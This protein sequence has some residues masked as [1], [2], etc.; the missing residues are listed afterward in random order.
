MT[1]RPT[2]LNDLTAKKIIDT[3]AAGGSR[4]AA[5]AAAGVHPSTV[6]RWL[7]E[8]RD[9]ASPYREF[10]ER[11]KG[12]E[13][14]AEIAMVTVVREAALKGTWQAAAWW[15]ERRR[16][17]LYALRRDAPKPLAEMTPEQA[18]ARY[19]ELTGHDWNGGRGDDLAVAESVVSA[20]RSRKADA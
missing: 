17:K 5:A 13:A 9:E 18:A 1:G 7:A 20:L 8:G 15:L 14:E 16:P 2:K 3:I 11:I 12:A 4:A 6:F 19:R 10:R